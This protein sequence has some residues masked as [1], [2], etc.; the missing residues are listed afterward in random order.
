[1]EKQAQRAAQKTTNAA[2]DVLTHADKAA[3]MFER[4]EQST[5]SASIV[6]QEGVSKLSNAMVGAGAFVAVVGAAHSIKKAVDEPSGVNTAR[7]GTSIVVAGAAVK[8]TAKVMTKGTLSATAGKVF[9]VASVL[10]ATIDVVENFNDPEMTTVDATFA[11][12]VDVVAAGLVFAG[13]VGIVAGIGL[14][15]ANN[16]WLKPALRHNN[17]KK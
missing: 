3:E 14:G 7:A 11:S 17:K 1:M 16:L 5:G 10:T 8:K 4:A 9:V 15:L 2:T 12:T 6:A 13:P